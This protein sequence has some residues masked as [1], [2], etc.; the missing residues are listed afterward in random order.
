MA[1]E[2]IPHVSTGDEYTG[3]EDLTIALPI[4]IDTGAMSFGM[5][6][7]PGVTFA[8]AKQDGGGPDL[9]ILHARTLAVH[10]D[11]HASGS[12]PLV[13][14]ADSFELTQTIDIAAH[15]DKPGPGGRAPVGPDAGTTLAGGAAGR[16]PTSPLVLCNAGAP[17][18]GGGAV[19]IYARTRIEISGI[20]NAAGGAGVAGIACLGSVLAPNPG[21]AGGMIVLQSPIVDNAGRLLASGGASGALVTSDPEIGGGGASDGEILLLY[22]T[23]VAAG[24]T[25]PTATLQ[26]Y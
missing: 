25:T 12:R 6:L 10:A 5:P 18:G 8:A 15:Q 24:S 4:T 22:R 19:E 7:P 13:L 2:D 11:V 26:P 1:T 20:I 16:A 21:G 17:G 9:A 23:K 3:V 14:I